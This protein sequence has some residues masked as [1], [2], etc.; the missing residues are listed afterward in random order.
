MKHFTLFLL[1]AIPLLT[2]GQRQGRIAYHSLEASYIGLN[3][4]DLLT[5]YKALG[6]GGREANPV[7]AIFIKNQAQAIAFKS[8]TTLGAL[9]LLRYCRKDHPKG[10][11]VS[12]IV[13]N[14]GMGYL[15]NHNYQLYLRI[16]I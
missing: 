15:V 2:N 4:L 13:L 16:K 10:A 3:A 7:M 1:L 14:V 12:L 5:T 9:A 6:A 11:L 8:V